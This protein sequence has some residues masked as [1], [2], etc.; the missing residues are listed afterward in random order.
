M[1]AA[2]RASLFLPMYCVGILSFVLAFPLFILVYY[3][4]PDLEWPIPYRQDP[5]LFC[6]RCTALITGSFI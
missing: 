4:F 3:R 6:D 2:V 5:D 1:N